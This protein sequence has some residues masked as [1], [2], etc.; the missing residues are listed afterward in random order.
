M[1]IND[2]I[3]GFIELLQQWHKNKTAQLRAI[4]VHDDLDMDIDG[5]KI[6]AKSELAKGI[7]FGVAL[8]LDLLGNLPF[9]ISKNDEPDSTKKGL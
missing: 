6:A 5:R 8:S 9:L 4:I 2:E 3:V 7:R 1:K